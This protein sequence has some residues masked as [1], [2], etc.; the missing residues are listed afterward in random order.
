MTHKEIAIAFLTA[1]SAGKASDA[2]EK[3]V[4]PDFR[5]HSPYFPGDRAA[6]LEA[7][8]DAHKRNPNRLF[9]IKQVVDGG[10]LVAIHAHVRQ[11]ADHPGAAVVNIFRFEDGKIDELWDVGQPIPADNLNEFGMF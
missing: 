11:N 3:Y 4:G 6:L 9:H 10:E 5:H 8:E 2:F 1:V 7:M